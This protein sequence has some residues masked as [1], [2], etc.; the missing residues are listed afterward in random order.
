MKND[1]NLGVNLPLSDSCQT[2]PNIQQRCLYPHR[3]IS[4]YIPIVLV[5]S[6]S[7][8]GQIRILEIHIVS[9]LNPVFAG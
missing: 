5:K 9:W 7:S 2:D 1:H 3:A 6:T 4:I 8:V